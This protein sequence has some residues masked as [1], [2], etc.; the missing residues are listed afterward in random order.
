[1]SDQRPKY[2]KLRNIANIERAAPMLSQ[3]SASY[4]PAHPLLKLQWQIGNQAVN[5]ILQTKLTV[6]S[7]DDEYEREADRVATQVVSRIN[8]PSDPSIQR[9][10]VNRK[11]DEDIMRQ[12][13][14]ETGS[15]AADDLGI[16][17]NAETDIPQARGGGYRLPSHIRKP[18]G[19][20]LGAD[21]GSAR[22]HLGADAE[23][24]NRSR[25]TLAFTIGQ[26][27][28]FRAGSHDP[29]ARSGQQLLAHELNHVVQQEGPP[30]YRDSNTP[31]ASRLRSTEVFSVQRYLGNLSAPTW[32]KPD[33]YSEGIWMTVLPGPYAC[34]STDYGSTADSNKTKAMTRLDDQFPGYD[35]KSGYL[36]K[37]N[38]EGRGDPS[39]GQGG[40]LNDRIA[41]RITTALGGGSIFSGP[42]CR[43]MEDAFGVQFDSVRI[44]HDAEANILNQQL[45]AAAFTVGKD[46]FFSSTAFETATQQGRHLLA[47]ELAH[48]L[49]QP[50]VV[51]RLR[52]H[53]YADNSVSRIGSAAGGA[54]RLQS[55]QTAIDNNGPYEYQ[56]PPGQTSANVSL[57]SAIRKIL[58][59][60]LSIGGNI[61][62]VNF[63]QILGQV[64]TLPVGTHELR[65]WSTPPAQSQD[66]VQLLLHFQIK[67]IPSGGVANDADLADQAWVEK[68]NAMTIEQATSR[69]FRENHITEPGEPE[70]TLLTV[71]IG[72]QKPS[73]LIELTPQAKDNLVAEMKDRMIA[74]ECTTKKIFTTTQSYPMF[75]I[76]PATNECKTFSAKFTYGMFHNDEVNF[77]NAKMGVWQMS[78]YESTSSRVDER[79]ITTL[80]SGGK[81]ALHKDTTQLAFI[82]PAPT[83][84]LVKTDP[85]KE[86]VITVQSPQVLNSLAVRIDRSRP[87]SLTG[88]WKNAE[89]TSGD[90]KVGPEKWSFTW[91][92]AATGGVHLIRAEG[93]TKKKQPT[94]QIS[95]EIDVEQ[96][97]KP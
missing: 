7:S 13:L 65:I 1:M 71:A 25:R 36:S 97:K 74:G 19:Q 45:G 52:T 86:Y 80:G 4:P 59:D 42:E 39:G 6:N 9:L 31:I 30:M 96:P 75:D 40:P 16:A 14:P 87:F 24:I 3:K 50:S 84:Q 38:E 2:T 37:N 32:G 10:G 21:L 33:S 94:K 81:S 78:H 77:G 92:T 18:L 67:V 29:Q 27:I 85:N 51:R 63:G 61:Q 88:D 93:R 55:A 20:I 69:P 35:R 91:T 82:N 23:R 95:R 28:F 56:L 26:D 64:Y 73:T 22:V 34:E 58:K 11:F 44:H 68:I 76:D 49:Q 12:A 62:G 83:G 54:A 57:M 66:P 17:A 60:L 46:I 53:D 90:G 47:H 48:T 5:R 89:R 15:L 70:R 41:S 8:S 72:R 43:L 79:I